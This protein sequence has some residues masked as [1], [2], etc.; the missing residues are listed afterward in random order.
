MRLRIA[1]ANDELAAQGM[2]VLGVAFRPLHSDALDG[3][4]DLVETGLTFV[5]MV[6]MMDPARP[7]AR[8]A[9]MTCRSAGIRP[10]MITG[11]HPLTAQAIA[12]QLGIVDP[13]TS[14]AAAAMA[15]AAGRAVPARIITG[16]EIERMSL[17]ELEAVVEETSVFAR[18]APEHKLKIVQALQDRGHIV[19]M[20]GDGVN[21]APALRKA[22]IGVAM[23]I[24]GTDVSKEAADM[25]LLDDNFATIVAAVKEGRVIYDNIR[26]F[27]K[28][29]MATNAAELAV[30][31]IAPFLGMPLPL[32]P[33]QIL[34][35]NLVT[36]GL[37]ALA[38]SLEPPERD[39]MRRPP[40]PPGESIFARGLGLH[41]LWAGPVMGVVALG[42]GWV[43]WSAGTEHWQ[44]MLFTVLT[45][46][47]MFHVLAVRVD[48]DSLFTAGPVLQPGAL[49]SGHAHA[50]AAGR[51]HLRAVPS[52]L[53]RHHASVGR[54]TGHRLR[55]QLD[56]SCGSSSC[57]SGWCVGAGGEEPAAAG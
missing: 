42:V 32:L 1:A 14:T 37:P 8:E 3:G 34:W 44:T 5:G 48:R 31:L 57:R 51:A 17:E 33:L 30:M 50:G 55:R 20:T 9:V 29:L 35:I 26:K 54:G 24:T 46:S 39:V 27:I 52:G 36:D 56:R 19:A 10:V 25:V 15:G 11:D 53:L 16:P 7:E 49:R 47:Q 21:D 38:L 41:V 22:S 45:I 43:Y 4:P 23:G 6:G 28:Y 40:H 13:A 2:R 18:V 12:E